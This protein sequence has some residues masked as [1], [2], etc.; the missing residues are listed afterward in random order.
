MMCFMKNLF[1]HMKS[2][3]QCRAYSNATLVFSTSTHPFCTLSLSL[4]FYPPIPVIWSFT[5]LI[6][7]D[8]GAS[9]AGAGG[10]C[11]SVNGG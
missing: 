7:H 8:D 6:L 9:A 3:I 2:R 10:C 4:F 5:S 1:F 11:A